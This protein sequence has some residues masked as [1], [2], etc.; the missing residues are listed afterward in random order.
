MGDSNKTLIDA[1]CNAYADASLA[2]VTAMTT[3]NDVWELRVGEELAWR[4][5]AYDTRFGREL[6]KWVR[7]MN[8]DQAH[9]LLETYSVQHY[10]TAGTFQN[11]FRCCVLHCMFSQLLVLPE[12]MQ[13][14]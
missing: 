8:Y 3:G 9:E 13:K 7:T 5:M 11:I 2:L 4:D 6:Y 1:H 10:T 14:K 12:Y